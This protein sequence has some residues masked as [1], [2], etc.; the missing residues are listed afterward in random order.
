[1]AKGYVKEGVMFVDATHVK[2]SANK[3]KKAKAEVLRESREYERDLRDEINRD[4]EAHGKKPFDDD[5]DDSPPETKTL[6]QSATDPDCGMFVK[7]EHE[8][9]FAYMVSTGCDKNGFV[10]GYDVCAGNVHDSMSFGKLYDKLK[11]FAPSVRELVKLQ[12]Q[13]QHYEK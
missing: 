4:R 6:T 9:Q 3:N 2:A 13:V 10:L 7:G 5:D 12:Y 1:M 8:R 11:E